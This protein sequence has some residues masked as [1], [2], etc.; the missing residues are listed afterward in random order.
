MSHLPWPLQP[1]TFTGLVANTLTVLRLPVPCRGEILS[2]S[3]VNTTQPTATMSL[4][5]YS[6]ES[7]AYAGGSLPDPEVLSATWKPVPGNAPSAYSVTRARIAATDGKWLSPA[8][9]SYHYVN[10][11]ASRTQPEHQLWLLINPNTGSGASTIV[12]SG[13]IAPVSEW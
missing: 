11:D 7:A 5:L 12:V 2:L 10:C 6:M 3:V 13:L 9:T 1:Q 8:N 4:E